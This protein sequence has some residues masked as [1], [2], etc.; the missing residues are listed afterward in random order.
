MAGC[1]PLLALF[2]TQQRLGACAVFRRQYRGIWPGTATDATIGEA[3]T[4]HFARFVDIAAIDEYWMVHGMLYLVHIERLELVP[5]GHND[6]G[7]CSLC[8]FV[9]ILAK[10]DGFHMYS[11]VCQRFTPCVCGD[12]VIQAHC[13]SLVCYPA[14]DVNR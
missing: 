7:V 3:E 13:C 14:D 4:F 11:R 9:G 12:G 8:Y 6:K 10:N 2:Y 1:R 5:L